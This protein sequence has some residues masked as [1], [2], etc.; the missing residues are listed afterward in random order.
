MSDL[1]TA[2]WGST[3]VAS[4]VGITLRQLYYWE[5]LGIVR[6]ERENFGDRKFRRYSA[7]DVQSLRRVKQL[8]DEGYVLN[9]AA[10][11]VLSDSDTQ[12]DSSS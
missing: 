1:C 11:K 4:R 5:R 6:P 9:R 12:G 7:R 10:E 3:E 8:V 2:T